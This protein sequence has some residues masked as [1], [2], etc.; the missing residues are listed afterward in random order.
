MLMNKEA[1]MGQQ[2]ESSHPFSRM[3]S[4]LD[5]TNSLRFVCSDRAMISLGSQTHAKIAHRSGVLPWKDT[6]LLRKD[7]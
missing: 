6:W 1:P 5:N 2:K 7:M 4:T 3:L